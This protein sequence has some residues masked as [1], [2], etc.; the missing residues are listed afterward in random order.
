MSR[1]D[2]IERLITSH[3]RRLQKLK[4]RQAIEG[5]TVDPKIP[6]EIEDIETEIEGLRKELETLEKEPPINNPFHYGGPVPPEGFVGHRRAVDFCQVKLTA[7]QPTNIAINGERRSG[8]T[9]FLH[10]LRKYSPQEAWG[11]HMCLFLDLGVLSGTLTATNFWQEIL[12]LLQTTLTSASSVAHQLFELLSRTDLTG[13]DFR[14]FLDDYYRPQTGQSIILLLDEFELIFQ[15]YNQEIKTLLINLRAITQDPTNKI[16]LITA[17]RDSLS[18]VCQPFTQET[19]LEFHSHFVPCQLEP[20]DEPETHYV[21]Q[22]LLSRSKVEFTAQELT[23][24]WQLSQWKKG[25]AHPFFVQ[26]AASL[27]FDYK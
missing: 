12:R 15:S 5:L 24:I 14:Q 7:P 26:M 2:D 22:T 3:T 20:F 11:Q 18:Q 9:S 4:E 23:Y 16:T 19:G 13:Q 21:V 27:I 25:G 10:Y 8:K 6:I 17:T 1:K